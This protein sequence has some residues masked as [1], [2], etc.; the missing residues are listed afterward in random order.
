MKEYEAE[1]G[2]GENFLQCWLSPN[3]KTYNRIYFEE[4]YKKIYD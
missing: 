4:H 2:F 3:E 1:A